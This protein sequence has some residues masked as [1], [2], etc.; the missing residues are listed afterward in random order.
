M[1][2]VRRSARLSNGQKAPA[3]EAPDR[4]I[5]QKILAHIPSSSSNGHGQ[6][7]GVEVKDGLVKIEGT[8]R[9]FHEKERLHR[10]VMGLRGVRALK[11][12][13]RVDPLESLADRQVALLV[14]QALDARSELPPGTVSVHCRSGV[15]SLVGH[16]RT[17]EESM[18]AEKV[19]RH[20]RGVKECVNELTVDPLDEVSDE[21]TAK[22]VKSALSYCTD[23]DIDS[24]A[25]SCADGKV[26]LRGVVPSIL[27][28]SLAEEVTR[29][30]NGVRAVENHIQVATHAKLDPITVCDNSRRNTRRIARASVRRSQRR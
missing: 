17:A 1:P 25:V 29:I 8:V 13:V 22:A 23:F 19:A 7:L 16:V 18:I 12:L 30:Q 5:R 3:T 9:T 27:D 20:T 14:R 10:F 4:E 11:D 2:F 24:I 26:V 21:A 6:A 28:R 15:C